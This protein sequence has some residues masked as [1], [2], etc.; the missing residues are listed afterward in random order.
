MATKQAVQ[1]KAKQAPAPQPR[2]NTPAVPLVFQLGENYII[3]IAGIVVVL[4]LVEY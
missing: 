3:M 4:L 1:Q 2:Q